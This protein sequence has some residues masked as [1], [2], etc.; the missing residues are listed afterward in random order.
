MAMAPLTSVR[1]TPEVI[2]WALAIFVCGVVVLPLLHQVGHSADHTHLRVH[3]AGVEHPHGEGDLL[4]FGLAVLE[5]ETFALV[6]PEGAWVVAE[7][8]APVEA[9]ARRRLLTPIRPG[10]P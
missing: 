8:R 5:A 9:P 6:L 4:H 3:A 2:L 10:A 7:V 1:R